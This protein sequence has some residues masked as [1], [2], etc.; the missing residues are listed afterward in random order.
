MKIGDSLLS[1]NLVTLK[2]N[3]AIFPLNRQLSWHF[4]HSRTGSLYDIYV[5]FSPLSSG[6]NCAR[7]AEMS[8]G[9]PEN[10][11]QSPKR[12]VTFWGT[13]RVCGEH[14]KAVS[15]STSIKTFPFKPCW[16]AVFY[17]TQ[18]TCTRRWTTVWVFEPYKGDISW[19]TSASPEP[20]H[21]LTDA[22]M[23]PA[24]SSVSR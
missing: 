12:H 9:E 7:C 16:W 3:T 1:T 14:D 18:A 22:A 13:F 20:H 8:G 10:C 19:I 11:K 2:T 4:A 5:L 17:K 23:L 15:I 6:T 21:V 24:V